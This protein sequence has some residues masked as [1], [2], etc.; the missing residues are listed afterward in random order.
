MNTVEIKNYIDGMVFEG[1]IDKA[2]KFVASMYISVARVSFTYCQA[3]YRQYGEEG[4]REEKAEIMK[5]NKRFGRDFGDALSAIKRADT[6]GLPWNTFNNVS[7]LKLYC[8]GAEKGLDVMAFKSQKELREAI[9]KVNNDKIDKALKDLYG[10]EGTENNGQNSNNQTN[11][12]PPK[13]DKSKGKGE[14]KPKTPKI[15]LVKK[16]KTPPTPTEI[17]EKVCALINECNDLKAIEAIMKHAQRR[18]ATLKD[19]IEKPRK[20]A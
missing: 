3:M 6:L 4:A 17:T 2:R 18:V 7:A 15:K 10:D 20:A 13:P 1:N 11:Q 8:Q 12:G 5:T 19:K 16:P 14:P 9:K